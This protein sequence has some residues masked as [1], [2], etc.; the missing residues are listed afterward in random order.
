VHLLTSDAA[1]GI[2]G[3]VIAKTVQVLSSDQVQ[4]TTVIDTQ[5]WGPI[6]NLAG[7]GIDLDTENLQQGTQILGVLVPA[8]DGLG[9]LTGF[10]PCLVATVPEPASLLL[11][12]AGLVPLLRGRRYV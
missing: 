5:T 8:A 3:A 4:T 7:V 6:Q 10:D 11:L 12:G 2:G 9:G 1:A